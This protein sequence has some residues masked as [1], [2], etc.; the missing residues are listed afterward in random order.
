VTSESYILAVCNV[1]KTDPE[2]QQRATIHAALARADYVVFN[3]AGADAHRILRELP[4]DVWGIATLA[5]ATQL[6]HAWRKETFKTVAPGRVTQIMRGGRRRF[7]RSRRR[8]RLGPS[9][10][11]TARRVELVQSGHRVRHCS[12]H[13]MARVFTAHPERKPLYFASVK[14]LN[15][16]LWA[17]RTIHEPDVL[18]G[19]MNRTPRVPFGP[20]WRRISLLTDLGRNRYTHCYVRPNGAAI[21]V[22]SAG[23][24]ADVPTD[25]DIQLIRI[26]LGDD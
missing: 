25:H 4:D 16:W 11:G 26:T 19:D 17:T 22:E 21:K 7:G 2:K 8:R 6:P 14:T 10:F 13:L 12:T 20:R 9:R 1:Q 23:E 3:E 15:S 5:G 24:I 18:A